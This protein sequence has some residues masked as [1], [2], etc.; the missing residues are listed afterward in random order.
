[1]LWD[2]DAQA[3]AGFLLKSG[4]KA[5]NARR[6]FSRDANPEDLAIATDYHHLDL[7]AADMSL[8][9]LDVQL[10]AEEAPKRLRKLL[11]SLRTPY[12]RVFLDCPPGLT[13]ISEQIF[14]AVNLIV[15]PVP[16]SPLAL[17]AYDAVVEHMRRLPQGGPQLVPVLSMVDARRKLHRDVLALHP[18]WPVIPLSSVIERMAVERAPLAVLAPRHPAARAFAELWT[19]VEERLVKIEASDPGAAAFG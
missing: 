5:A 13:E 8:R 1:L 14:R 19:N 17:R 6:I 12:D 18:G 7:L 10:A 16:P 2:I 4:Q 11:N 9:R 15:V 3:A